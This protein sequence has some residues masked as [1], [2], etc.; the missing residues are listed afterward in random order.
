VR[1]EAI[2]KIRNPNGKIKATDSQVKDKT[3]YGQTTF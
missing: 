1:D 2:D 3:T